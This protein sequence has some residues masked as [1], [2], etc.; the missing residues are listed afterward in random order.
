M[1]E[2]TLHRYPLGLLGIAK[3]RCQISGRSFSGLQTYHGQVGPD[4]LLVPPLIL[5]F[6]TY[7]SNKGDGKALLIF[8]IN[9]TEFSN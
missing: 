2:R 9:G 6:F 5:C 3:M 4:S 1:D 8:K 7:E